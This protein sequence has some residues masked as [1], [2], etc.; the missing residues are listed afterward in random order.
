MSKLP[1]FNPELDIQIE[2]I[3]PTT[4]SQIFKGWTTPELLEEWFC[5][6]PW[7]VTKAIVDLKP[8]GRFYTMMKGPNPGEENGIEGCFLE[9]VKDEK[10]IWTDTMTEGFRPNEK[11]FMTGMLL[12][13]DHPQG[14]KYTARACHKNAADRKMHADMGFEQ[15]WNAVLD[16]LIE[17]MKTK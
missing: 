6:K 10:L 9:I 8:G 16:Q 14:T 13:E 17:L 12:L 3:V 7:K 11:S 5:P 2:R 1:P 4:R 15:G